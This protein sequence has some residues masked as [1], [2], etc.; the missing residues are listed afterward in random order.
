[1]KRYTANELHIVMTL[2]QHTLGGFP[3]G[4][5]SFRK[6]IVDILA[7]LQSLSKF[8]RFMLKLL[9]RELHK[10]RFQCINYVDRLHKTFDIT[11]I[12]VAKYLFH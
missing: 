12:R 3:Y 7:F 5:K 11:F 10:F 8:Y 6:N 2:A 4:C 1:M 9:V